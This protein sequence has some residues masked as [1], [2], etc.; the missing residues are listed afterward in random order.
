MSHSNYTLTSLDP[1]PSGQSPRCLYL[2]IAY[3]DLTA[4]NLKDLGLVYQINWL[5][6][7][8][9][10]MNLVVYAKSKYFFNVV[11]SVLFFQTLL[12]NQYFCWIKSF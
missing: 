3:H 4:R 5:H 12:K 11:Y 1:V 6:R 9:E 7:K 8:M 2:I 10:T